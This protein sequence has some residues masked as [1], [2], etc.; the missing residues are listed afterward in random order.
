MIKNVR[1]VSQQYMENRVEPSNKIA[2]ISI[3]S[4]G[5]DPACIPNGFSN[6]LRITFD[7]LYEE[8]M[9]VN[10]GSIPDAA[11]EGPLLWHNIELFD[12]HHARTILNFIN[13]LECKNIIVH[14]HAGISRS[15][16]IAK[17]ISQFYGAILFGMYDSDTTC[18]NKRVLRLLNKVANKEEL[19]FG[20]YIPAD[21][22]ELGYHEIDNYYKGSKHEYF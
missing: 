15:A 19:I 4:K 5:D 1:F 17:F 10:V 16:A 12:V 13:N 2:V 11:I 14:C 22:K 8:T 6:I 3:T 9:N 18:A 7:D 20:N 21:P